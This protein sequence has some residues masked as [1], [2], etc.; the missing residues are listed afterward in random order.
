MGEGAVSFPNGKSVGVVQIVRNILELLP[1]DLRP[2]LVHVHFDGCGSLEK[3]EEPVP[4]VTIS[5]YDSWVY[6]SSS[7]HVYD[8]HVV[9]CVQRVLAYQ[10]YAIEQCAGIVAN[11]LTDLKGMLSSDTAPLSSGTSSADVASI[12][13]VLTT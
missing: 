5:G 6:S 7:S 11:A 12:F 1:R 2:Y 10:E 4:G 8:R 9:P 13:K 3:V